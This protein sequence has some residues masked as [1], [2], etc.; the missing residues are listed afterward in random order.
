MLLFNQYILFR[1][2]LPLHYETMAG[3]IAGICQVCNKK[4]EK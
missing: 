3:A 4:F 2:F 1:S